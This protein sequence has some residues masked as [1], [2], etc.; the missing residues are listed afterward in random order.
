MY[1]YNWAAF[2]MDVVV[3]VTAAVTRNWWVLLLTL[4]T[5]PYKDGQS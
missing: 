1:N 4:L 2:L 3:I 5:G